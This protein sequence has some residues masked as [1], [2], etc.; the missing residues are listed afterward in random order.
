MTSDALALNSQKLCHI[1]QNGQI[2]MILRENYCIQWQNIG[3]LRALSAATVT[4]TNSVRWLQQNY[5]KINTCTRTLLCDVGS[6]KRRYMYM[7][8]FKID[9]QKHIARITTIILHS[10]TS[11]I[12]DWAFSMVW[13]TNDVEQPQVGSKEP[14]SNSIARLGEKH[15]IFLTAESKNWM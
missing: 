6:L 4:H 15:K 3:Y 5:G 13:I 11:C 1:N 14:L 8:I 2:T 7:C 9:V 12:S 10:D